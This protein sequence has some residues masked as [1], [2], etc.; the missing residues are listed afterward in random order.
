[1]QPLHRKSSG[2]NL[3]LH[4][5]LNPIRR[6]YHT[7][8]FERVEFLGWEFSGYPILSCPRLNTNTVLRTIDSRKNLAHPHTICIPRLMGEPSTIRET[9]RSDES[10]ILKS[11]LL[12]GSELVEKWTDDI[13]HLVSGHAHPLPN[14]NDLMPTIGIQDDGRQCPRGTGA[15]ACVESD[16]VPRGDDDL[17]CRGVPEHLHKGL[18]ASHSVGYNRTLLWRTA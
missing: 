6:V 16:V 10:C 14:S 5:I 9:T 3:S 17:C 13:E 1:M 2:L 15:A 8:V 7:N 18:E 12:F 4:R 11:F